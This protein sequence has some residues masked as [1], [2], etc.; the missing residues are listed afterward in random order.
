MRIVFCGVGAVGSTAAIFCRNLPATL[1]FVDFDR[2]ESKN[3]LAQAYTKP[4]LGKNK[5]EALKAQLLSFWGIK[6]E[7]FGVRVGQEN[8]EALCGAADLVVDAFDNKASRVVLSDFARANEK[9]LVHAAISGDGTFGLVRWDERFVPD[10]ED[11]AGQAT[12]EGGEHLPMLGALGASLA[13]VIQDFAKGGERRD[14]MVSL[15][16]VTTTS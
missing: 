9:P 4:S 5:A 13:R 7:A 12:C 10:A 8:V 16:A 1:V 3:L 2:V 14:V 6:T 11:H 15:A